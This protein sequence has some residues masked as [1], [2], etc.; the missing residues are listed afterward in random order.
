MTRHACRRLQ[1][2]SWT[3]GSESA[4]LL[5]NVLDPKNE[6]AQLIGRNRRLPRDGS[7]VRF[8]VREGDLD[9][10]RYL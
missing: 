7:R 10:V 6:S 3:A 9:V 2:P 4:D 1:P 5:F 8:A